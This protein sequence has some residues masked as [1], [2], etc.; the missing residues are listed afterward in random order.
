MDRFGGPFF[1]DRGPA[2]AEAAAWQAVPV[3]RGAVPGSKA[4]IVGGPSGREWLVLAVRLD[5]S[6]SEDRS[7]TNSECL[8]PLFVSI[9]GMMSAS[10]LIKRVGNNKIIVTI[11]LSD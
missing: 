11:Q 9:V 4:G 2:F 5:N 6:R 8:I 7:Y 1:V 10:T 3:S